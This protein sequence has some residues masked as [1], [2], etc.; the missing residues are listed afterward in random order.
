[1]PKDFLE[2]ALGVEQG[3][4]PETDTQEEGS[5]HTWL[6]LQREGGITCCAEG[7][8]EAQESEERQEAL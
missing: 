1:M 4:S 3:S 6:I 2:V 8:I 5:R 7:C